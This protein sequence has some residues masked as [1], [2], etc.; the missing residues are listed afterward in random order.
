MNNT[1]Q[2]T[3]KKPLFRRIFEILI[4]L[5]CIFLIFFVFFVFAMIVWDDYFGL[6]SEYILKMIFI[7]LVVG[8]ILVS[9]TNRKLRYF[10]MYIVST[11]TIFFSG[12]L[13]ITPFLMDMPA[14]LNEDYEYTSGEITDVKFK[15]SKGSG[16]DNVKK[17]YIDG[18]KYKIGMQTIQNHTLKKILD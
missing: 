12:F 15:F 17:F 11:M 6:L 7:S 8:V 3:S 10:V 9:S 13:L 14:Y 2:I 5:H 1:E 4:I 16:E 18:E